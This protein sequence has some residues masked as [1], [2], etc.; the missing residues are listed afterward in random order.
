MQV[1]Q[2]N[3]HPVKKSSGLFHFLMF[4]FVLGVMGLIFNTVVRGASFTPTGAYQDIIEDSHRE[5][6]HGFSENFTQEPRAVKMSCES[7]N[8]LVRVGECLREYNFEIK[9]GIYHHVYIEPIQGVEFYPY[10]GDKK[11]YNFK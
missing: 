10:E 5:Q 3:A 6:Y 9:K 7:F 4:L 2:V 11:I 1:A 8:K